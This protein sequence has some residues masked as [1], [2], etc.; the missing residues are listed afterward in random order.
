MPNYWLVKTEPATYSLADL[1]REGE[2]RWTG[3]ANP[4]A[5]GHLRAMAE[6]DEVFVYHTGNERRIVGIAVVTE[7]GEEPKLGY[8]KQLPRPVPLAEI[9]GR[10][11][12]ADWELVR[13][14]RL[15]VMPVN[16]ARWQLLL[17]AGAMP[18]KNS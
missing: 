13:Q 15:S 7:A 18:V 9:K 11:E 3:V 14:G 2:T 1:E 8:R 16:A 6:G 17:R 12:F 4:V 5:R 10:K